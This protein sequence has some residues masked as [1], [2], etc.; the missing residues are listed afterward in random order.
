[1]KRKYSVWLALMLSVVLMVAAGCSAGNNGE[2]PPGSDTGTD[3]IQSG[4]V[5][6]AGTP[7]E[8]GEGAI[9][10]GA[11]TDPGAES[12]VPTDAGAE[13]EAPADTGAGGEAPED[14]QSPAAS[15]MLEE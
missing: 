3:N 5:P 8:D 1:M 15:G 13:S 12:E 2:T 4:D 10:S 6:S 11:S 7:S 9:D 14:S